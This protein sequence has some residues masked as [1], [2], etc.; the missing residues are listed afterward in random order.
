MEKHDELS[1]FMNG[2]LNDL[3]NKHSEPKSI[4]LRHII[5]ESSKK[6]HKLADLSLH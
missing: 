1:N 5:E 2:V 3:L 4:E 6:T